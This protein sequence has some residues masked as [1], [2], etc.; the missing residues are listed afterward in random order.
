[1]SKNPPLTLTPTSYG[2][3][4]NTCQTLRIL[5]KDRFSR[6]TSKKANTNVWQETAASAKVFYVITTVSS[7]IRQIPGT[8]KPVIPED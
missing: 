1:M 6:L 2:Q 7:H 4:N 5:M 3:R 8:K